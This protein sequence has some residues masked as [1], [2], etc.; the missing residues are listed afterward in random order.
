VAA[1][2][3]LMVESAT[4]LGADRRE[5]EQQLLD[6]L[7]FETTLANVSLSSI[8]NKSLSLYPCALLLALCTRRERKRE[9]DWERRKWMK[10]KDPA[11]PN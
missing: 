8:I 6:V 9:R 2:Y 10:R 1:Y 11:N 4:L 3:N 5:A 7:Q